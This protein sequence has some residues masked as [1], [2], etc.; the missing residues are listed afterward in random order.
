MPSLN[1]CATPENE[2]SIPGPP[3]GAKTPIVAP[4]VD[5]LMPSA[6]PTPTRS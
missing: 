1:D 3:C 2:F 4:L 6:I 5:R